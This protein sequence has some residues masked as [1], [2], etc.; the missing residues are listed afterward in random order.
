MS[1]TLEFGQSATHPSLVICPSH[2]ALHLH[3]ANNCLK[4]N[5][6]LLPCWSWKAGQK[7]PSLRQRSCSTLVIGWKTELDF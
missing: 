6:M 1:V 4:T 3:G 5:Y 2:H 7:D